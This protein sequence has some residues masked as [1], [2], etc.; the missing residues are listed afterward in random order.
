MSFLD[1]LLGR[2]ADQ[3]ATPT[4]TSAAARP[5]TDEQAIERYRYMLRTAPPEDIERAHA[6]AF[7]QL[8]AEQRRAVL[9]ELSKHVPESEA[10]TASDDPQ[11]LARLATRAEM[12]RPGTLERSFGSM[13]VPG[14]GMGSMLLTVMAGSFIGTAIAQSFFDEQGYDQGMAADTG[15]GET[16]AT[17]ADYGGEA[18][19]DYGAEAGADD[20]GGID[21]GDFGG[22]DFGGDF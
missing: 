4:G 13:A 2:Q 15:E 10:R 3:S 16:D 20:G 8:T 17:E 12:R 22:G 1:R 18:G 6:E 9:G 21:G 19:A 14:M 7:A 11:G 5:P